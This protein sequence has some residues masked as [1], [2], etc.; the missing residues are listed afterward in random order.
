MLVL[1]HQGKELLGRAVPPG[2]AA[3]ANQVAADARFE[4]VP[5]APRIAVQASGAIV[6]LGDRDLLCNAL[7]NVVRNAIRHGNIDGHGLGLAI[8]QRVMAAASAPTSARTAACGC[9]SACRCRLEP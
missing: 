4:P 3:L 6:V 2:L 8:A 5:A 7:E 9:G 1:D